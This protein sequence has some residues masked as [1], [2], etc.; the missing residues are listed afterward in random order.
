[1][2]ISIVPSSPFIVKET[3]LEWHHQY[4]APSPPAYAPDGNAGFPGYESYV[5][6]CG[7]HECQPP[8]C[9]PLVPSFMNDH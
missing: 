5:S 2:K 9:K 3:E 8:V 6:S 4:H 1:M 7:Y